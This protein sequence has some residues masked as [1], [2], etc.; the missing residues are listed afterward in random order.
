MCGGGVADGLS[1]YLFIASLSLFGSDSPAELFPY[2][3]QGDC[4]SLRGHGSY[5]LGSS[6]AGSSLSGV[7]QLPLRRLASFGLVVAHA[8]LTHLNEFVLH[9]RFQLASSQLVLSSIHRPSWMV[10]MQLKDAYL[11]IPI[12]PDSHKNLCFVVD[13]T[14][15]QFRGLC[16]G[17][18]TA[19]QVF[20]RS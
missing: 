12:H 3:H 13:G 10:S 7:L 9:T 8:R 6:R 4:S 5:A 16:F 15:Y 20:P 1:C 18:S 14:V 2:L 19:P 17:L 11:H